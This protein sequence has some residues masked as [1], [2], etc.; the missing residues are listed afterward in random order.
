MLAQNFK[1]AADLGI[2]G[3][4]HAA[5]REVLR[6]LEVG[7]ITDRH[8]DMGNTMWHHDCGTVGCIVGW[9]RKINS[10]AFT[11]SVGMIGCSNYELY[12][13]FMNTK[14]VGKC[15]DPMQGAYAL[16]NYL[17]LGEA[18]WHEVIS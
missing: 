6:R 15:R 10:R 11:R 4:E 16:R 18:R 8:F 14:A 2:S 1:T 5:L 7:E 9:A 17:T 12:D 3:E 13:L